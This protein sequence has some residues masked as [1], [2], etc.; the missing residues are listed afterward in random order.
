MLRECTQP[1][2]RH[3][4]LPGSL[5]NGVAELQQLCMRRSKCGAAW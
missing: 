1:G 5:L 3:S 2:E 4:R